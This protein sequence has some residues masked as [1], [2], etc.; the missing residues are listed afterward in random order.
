MSLWIR[1]IYRYFLDGERM[2]IYILLRITYF[3]Y[4][5]PNVLE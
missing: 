1:K 2:K 5:S 3:W 4:A